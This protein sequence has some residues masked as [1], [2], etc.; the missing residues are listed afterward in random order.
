MGRDS[1]AAQYF[2]HVISAF[3]N[4]ATSRNNAKKMYSVLLQRIA[5]NYYDQRKF[6]HGIVSDGFPSLHALAI[7]MFC[8]STHTRLPETISA[9]TKAVEVA[10]DEDLPQLYAMLGE[11]QV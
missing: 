6:A 1:E 4:D 5:T 9:F 7:C 3:G 2:D 10:P 8:C 11:A